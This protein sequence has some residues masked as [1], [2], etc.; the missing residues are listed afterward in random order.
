MKIDYQIFQKRADII[1]SMAHPARLIV[2]ESLKDGEKCVC[3]LNELV[4]L[5]QSTLSR[6]LLILKNAGI[7]Q[8]TKRGQNVYYKLIVPCIFKYIECIYNAIN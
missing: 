6:H 5:D 3:K 1:K 4:D 8:S 7:V 2:L